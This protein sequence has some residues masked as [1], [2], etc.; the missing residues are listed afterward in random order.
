M[1]T[2]QKNK[3]NERP[4]ISPRSFLQHCWKLCIVLLFIANC[5]LAG[6]SLSGTD[7]IKQK[8]AFDDP[9]NPDCP[10]HKYQKLAEAE[11]HALLIKTHNYST[12]PLAG[13]YEKSLPKPFTA[14]TVKSKKRNKADWFVR[15]KWNRSGSCRRVKKNKHHQT[16]CARWS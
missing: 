10:C 11:Y 8:Y 14:S 3:R 6:S 15:H 1:L 7:S 16:A 4:G 13:L 5:S 9:N 12:D 2:C